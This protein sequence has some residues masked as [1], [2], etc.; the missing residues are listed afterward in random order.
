VWDIECGACL[1]VLEGHDELVRCIRF[2]SKRIVSGAYDG[3][4]KIW[5]LQAA[6]DPRS[7][8]SSLCMKT[9]TE[10]TGRVFR[11]QFD[12][13]Q[14]VSSSHDDTILCFNFLQPKGVAQT[15][16]TNFSAT[17]SP[18]NEIANVLQTQASA[19]SMASSSLGSG[20]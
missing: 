15:Q 12:E 4:I 19:I 2:D 6:L 10:H 14:I 7:Q 16:L 1:R 20:L 3:K 11:L 18:Q 8:P 13:F 9:L 5:D 17:D